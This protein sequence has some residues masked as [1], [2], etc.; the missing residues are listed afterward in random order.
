MDEQSTATVINLTPPKTHMH[1]V[2][3]WM[4]SPLV[5]TRV[6][7]NHI[8]TIRLLSGLLAAWCF[9][10][11]ETGWHAWGGLIFIFSMLMDRADGELARMTGKSSRWG[12]W[13]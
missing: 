13:Y 3:R 8:T 6:T 4:M 12:H 11:P 10:T 9:S 7:P 5:D 1:A 2:A